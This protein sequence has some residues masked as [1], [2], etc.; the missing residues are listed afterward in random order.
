MIRSRWL[1][2]TPGGRNGALEGA[3]C[4]PR[5]HDNSVRTWKAIVGKC[6]ECSTQ[7]SDASLGFGGLELGQLFRR[8]C[9]FVRRPT[10]V[11][12]PS[13]PDA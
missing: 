3:L 4:P 10:S 9:A 6:Q 12:V 1:P 5:S 8:S 2:G 11:C 7:R 13:V